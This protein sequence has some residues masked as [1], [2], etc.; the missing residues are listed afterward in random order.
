M[1]FKG[2][3][4]IWYY[5]L[6][7]ICNLVMIEPIYHLFTTEFRL[8]INLILICSFLV[9]NIS[10][11]PFVVR[12]YVILDTDCLLIKFGFCNASI[13]YKDIKDV[14]TSHNPI[15]SSAAS[16]DRIAIISHT[17]NAMAYIA[18]RKKQ[19]FLMELRKRI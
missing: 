12:N 6:I 8:G 2:K 1:R 17:G 9:L 7:I 10:L 13:P 5:G 3:V 16:L 14:K 4:A 11:I 19:Q 15:A 18:V